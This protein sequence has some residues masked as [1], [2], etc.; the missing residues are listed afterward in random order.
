MFP[1]SDMNIGIVCEGITDYYVIEAALNTIIP[2]DFTVTRIQPDVTPESLNF[3]GGWCGV[4]KWCNEVL[5]HESA[6]TKILR[7]IY[8]IVIIHID[9]DVAQKHFRDCGSNYNNTPGLPCESKC[10]PSEDTVNNLKTLLESWMPANPLDDRTVVCIP[11]KS[12]ETWVVTALFG[13]N[14]SK[15]LSDIE[16]NNELEHYL[17]EKPARERL[18][19]QKDGRF[20]KITNRYQSNMKTI[21]NK[22]NFVTKHCRE[23]DKFEGNIISTLVLL[24][25]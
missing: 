21:S 12:S 19:R 20:K 8:K 15:I 3:G 24:D 10:P 1:Q 2:N 22:W 6:Q 11:S 14:D 9:A 16:C 5:S 25:L 23:A 7:S 18:I 4:F 17:S 13:T